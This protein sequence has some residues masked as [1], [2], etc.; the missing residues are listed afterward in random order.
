[1]YPFMTLDDGT[2]IVHSEMLPDGRIKFYLEKP[3][4]IDCFHSATCY[5]PG[6]DWENIVGFTEKE[7]EHYQTI[8]ES[9]ELG[10]I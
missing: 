4:V 10:G 8:L 1:M 9:T 5:L 3:D 7:I 6:Y 2:E